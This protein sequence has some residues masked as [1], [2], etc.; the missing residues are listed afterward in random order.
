MDRLL[1]EPDGTGT[2]GR[3]G[4]EVELPRAMRAAKRLNE[5]FGRDLHEYVH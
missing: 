2:E 4:A 5:R 3:E 1:P